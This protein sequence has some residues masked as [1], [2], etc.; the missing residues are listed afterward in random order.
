GVGKSA[1]AEG[2]AQRIVNRDVPASL[3]GRLYSLD[4][5]AL[6]AGA[7]SKGEYEEHIKA[8]LN[9]VEKAAS[10]HHGSEGGRTD[11]ANLFKP[12]L[13]RGKLRCIGA[14]TLAEYRQYIEKDPA[15]ERRFAQVLINEPSVPETTSTLRGV[16]EKY[17][18]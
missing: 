4:M 1:I 3:L 17:T 10:P 16:R 6:M 18:T 14:T 11:T 5:G 7:K 8:V 13:A 9:E 2:L 12:L 15:L